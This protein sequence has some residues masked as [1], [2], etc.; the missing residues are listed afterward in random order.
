[1]EAKAAMEAFRRLVDLAH[2]AGRMAEFVPFDTDPHAI[3]CVR[4][5]VGDSDIRLLD[6]VNAEVCVDMTS[7]LIKDGADLEGAF[8]QALNEAEGWM[9]TDVP[10]IAAIIHDCEAMG[11]VGPAIRPLWKPTLGN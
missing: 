6:G 2:Q 7:D 10:E 9:D 8:M 4:V 5:H 1:M 11:Q 3:G